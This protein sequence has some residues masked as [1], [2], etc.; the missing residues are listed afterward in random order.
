MKEN[1]KDKKALEQQAEAMLGLLGTQPPLQARP[2]MFTRIEQ[3][4]AN[5]QMPP[6]ADKMPLWQTVALSLCLL[7]GV[8]AGLQLG[9]SG[10]SIS[11]NGTTY[12]TI[13]NSFDNM[14]LEPLETAIL[15]DADD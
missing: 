8:Y 15:Q 13:E 6:Q 11:A 1:K 14:A 3:A 12:Y 10:G 5:R 2:F 4:L 7:L 9:M